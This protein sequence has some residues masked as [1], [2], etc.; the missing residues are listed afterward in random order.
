MSRLCGTPEGRGT[1]FKNHYSFPPRHRRRE[2]ISLPPP[3]NSS[4]LPV[5]RRH[6]ARN[7]CKL[8]RVKHFVRMLPVLFGFFPSR[9]TR[10][11]TGPPTAFDARPSHA[12]YFSP[13]PSVRVVFP[14]SSPISVPSSNSPR[15]APRSR[16]RPQKGFTFSP[17]P[18]A[19]TN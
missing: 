9:G 5:W 13:R 7:A 4:T 18:D 3:R 11:D 6:G 10:T 12:R 19:K 16:R 15:D 14:F 8:Y 17:M 2:P 1:Q